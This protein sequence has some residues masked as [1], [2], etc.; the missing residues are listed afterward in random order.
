M[1]LERLSLSVEMEGHRPWAKKQ[2]NLVPGE[3]IGPNVCRCIF[4]G[5]RL[6]E[7]LEQTESEPSV[8]PVEFAPALP[9]AD[10]PAPQSISYSRIRIVWLRPLSGQTRAFWNA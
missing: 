3:G 2:Q 4:S 1:A 9:T 7:C 6:H 10:E 5:R 8:S